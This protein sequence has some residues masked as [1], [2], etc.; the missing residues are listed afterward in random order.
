MVASDATASVASTATSRPQRSTEIP[1]KEDCGESAVSAAGTHGVGGT[2]TGDSQQTMPSWVKRTVGA[3][4]ATSPTPDASQPEVVP[5]FEIISELGSGGMGVVY[6]ARQERLKRL[7]A[8]KMIR[9]DW[10]GSSEYLA[11]FEIEA[12]VVAR[13]N[14][15]NILRIYEIGRT[16][17]G[18][19]VALELPGGRDA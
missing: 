12:E 2:R 6:K 8:L 17:R 14:H 19:Y 15:A 4:K 13:L 18:P 3:W 16:E 10:L 1:S 5:G 11:R 9:G 7:V